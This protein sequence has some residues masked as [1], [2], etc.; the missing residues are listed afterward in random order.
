[1]E[2]DIVEMIKRVERQQIEC[3]SD[4]VTAAVWEY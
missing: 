2:D 4:R 1:M 3:K